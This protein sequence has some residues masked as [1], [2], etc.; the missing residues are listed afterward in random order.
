MNMCNQD[1]GE[2]FDL[3]PV[4]P[5]ALLHISG[6]ESAVNQ[7]SSLSMLYERGVTRA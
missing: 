4:A 3:E 1:A 7:E 6:T 2:I 5:E